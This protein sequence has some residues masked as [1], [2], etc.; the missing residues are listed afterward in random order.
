MPS[1]IAACASG[2][3]PSTATPSSNSI[4]GQ[5]DGV[6]VL[7]QAG[8]LGWGF[9]F[10]SCAAREYLSIASFISGEGVEAA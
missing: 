6:P 7:L 5:D 2:S 3:L 9:F 1:T 8:D 4:F 10:F